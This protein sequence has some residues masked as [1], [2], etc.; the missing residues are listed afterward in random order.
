MDLLELSAKLKAIAVYQPRLADAVTVPLWAVALSVAL[1]LAFG[2][3]VWA[4]LLRVR[5]LYT[6]LEQ[7]S[8]D[9]A[10]L[11]EM[12]GSELERLRELLSQSQEDSESLDEMLGSIL[13]GGLPGHLELQSRDWWCVKTMN[14]AYTDQD[15]ERKEWTQ[16]GYH[17]NCYV[18]G[19]ASDIEVTFGVVGGSECKRVDRSKTSCPYVY[20]DEGRSVPEKFTY[21]RC[22]ANV[23]YEIRG[24]SLGAFI[25]KVTE[26]HAPVREPDGGK[27]SNTEALGG[28][29]EK[30]GDLKHRS[31]ALQGLE[32]RQES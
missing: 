30:H 6:Q 14:V 9:A 1:H 28:G 8:E 7:S 18:P 26:V 13:K 22:P 11:S 20:D 5:N 2:F 4:L 32:Q 10:S 19:G 15:G 31:A 25:S 21:E 23:R 12:F 17:V 24:P 3:V 27:P 16:S 29:E